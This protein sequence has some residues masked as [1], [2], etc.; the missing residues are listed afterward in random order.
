MPTVTLQWDYVNDEWVYWNKPAEGDGFTVIPETLGK[1]IYVSSSTGSNSN[2]GLSE[3]NPVETI[4]HAVSLANAGD[5]VLLLCGDTWIDQD[6]DGLEGSGDMNNPTVISYY[7]DI[8]LGRPKMENG[9]NK[10]YSKTAS[11][12]SRPSGI[13]IIGL[14]MMKYKYKVGDPRFDNSN[15]A[16]DFKAFSLL[17]ET[18]GILIE[19]CVFDHAE[20]VLQAFQGGAVSGVKLRRNIHTGVYT[21]Q[22]TFN[23]NYVAVN[24]YLEGSTDGPLVEECVFD[25]GGWSRDVAGAGANQYNHN[26]YIQADENGD[27]SNDGVYRN[28]IITRASSHGIHM[29]PGGWSDNNFF[30]RNAVQVQGG[31][32]SRPLDPTDHFWVD[33]CV[34]SETASMYK[35]FQP[36]DWTSWDNGKTGALWG[37]RMP[38]SA[39]NP[40]VRIDGCIVSFL[41]AETK[42]RPA[43]PQI[44]DFEINNLT[45]PVNTVA[46]EHNAGTQNDNYDSQ[47]NITNGTIYTDPDRTL[48]TWYTDIAV[49]TGLITELVTNGVIDNPSVGYDDF[50]S[51]INVFKARKVG[52]WDER[53]TA[54]A[55]NN[56]IR[57]GYD[58]APIPN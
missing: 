51:A 54:N 20:V 31:Y 38:P 9:D 23:R 43:F 48:G 21:F 15:V 37:I 29:R 5:H 41:D 12:P 7:G 30:G 53:L 2:D 46:Y 24:L 52:Q 47:G 25:S 34:F 56:Y 27:Q 8:S 22:S 19:D 40:D 11:N 55:V 6:F 13:F 57:T 3:Q 26:M 33:N 39:N 45:I 14:D 58:F 49:G 17:G 44:A 4:F 16:A 36:S 1:T 35:G 10:F 32:S 50:D 18:A 28:N 42:D